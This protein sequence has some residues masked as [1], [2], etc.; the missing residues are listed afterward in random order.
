M[1]IALVIVTAI[2]VPLCH[3]L[4]KWMNRKAFGRYADE[5]KKNIEAL[6]KEN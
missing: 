4:A 3:Q 5:L 1:I 2:L 6:K